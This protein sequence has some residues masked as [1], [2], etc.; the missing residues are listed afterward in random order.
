[1]AFPAQTM[2]TTGLHPV[3]V[4]LDIHGVTVP[5]GLHTVP[6]LPYPRLFT[7]ISSVRAL[8]VLAPAPACASQPSV[9]LRVPLRYDHSNR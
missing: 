1:M 9:Q 6:L 4:Q 7:L 3:H 8:T 5:L 2:P